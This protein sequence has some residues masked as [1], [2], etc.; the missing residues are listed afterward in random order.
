MIICINIVLFLVVVYNLIKIRRNIFK[1]NLPT[2][3]ILAACI[4]AS[5]GFVFWYS[6]DNSIIGLIMLYHSSCH[7]FSY[8]YK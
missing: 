8:R 3:S 5:V 1:A 2:M 7:F 4:L 6:H